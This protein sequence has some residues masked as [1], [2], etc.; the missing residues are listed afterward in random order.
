VV[1]RTRAGL[2]ALIGAGLL[3]AVAA[4]PGRAGAQVLL[5]DDFEY[6]PAGSGVHVVGPASAG[7]PPLGAVWDNVRMAHP[8]ALHVV[9]DGTAASGECYVSE[10]FLPG[11]PGSAE[12]R[13]RADHEP[14]RWPAPSEELW[15]RHFVRWPKGWTWPRFVGLK[16]GRLRIRE[17]CG[18]GGSEGP[19]VETYWGLMHGDPSRIQWAYGYAEPGQR[20]AGT[21]V[22]SGSWPGGFRTDRWYCLELH[23]RQNTTAVPPD[24]LLEIYVD[25]ERVAARQGVSTRGR[26][27]PGT[28]AWTIVNVADNFVGD[29]GRGAATE[30]TPAVHF[31]GVVVATERAS[32]PGAGGRRP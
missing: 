7:R 32:C 3:V 30:R 1:V 27:G 10:N 11:R 26:S 4:A 8:D 24:G 17:S 25:G 29:A 15:I 14:S 6:F 5:Q 22:V 19:C 13:D 23:V 9:C 16:L 12:L 21:T 2:A 18:Q 31:D 28:F 20:W